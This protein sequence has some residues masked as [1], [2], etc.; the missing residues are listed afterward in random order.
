MNCVSGKV[1]VCFDDE[2]D[3]LDDVGSDDR[4]L[5]STIFKR[6]IYLCIELRINVI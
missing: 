3:L 2:L 1:N 6:G 5:T 4:P